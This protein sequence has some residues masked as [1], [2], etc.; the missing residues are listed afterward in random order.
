MFSNS[1]KNTLKIL[2]SYHFQFWYFSF[3]EVYLNSTKDEF[4]SWFSY[5]IKNLFSFEECS[6]AQ[7]E[8]LPENNDVW[9]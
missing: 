1:E 9:I 8:Y 3:I 4:L 2:T 6:I 5:Y 7:A